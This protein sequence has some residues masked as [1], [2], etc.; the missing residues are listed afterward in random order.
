MVKTVNRERENNLKHFSKELEV[1]LLLCFDSKL[2]DAN[3]DVAT[4]FS[5]LVFVSSI[6]SSGKL[7]QHKSELKRLDFKFPQT[8]SLYQLCRQALPFS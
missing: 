4:L 1:G 5:S 8:L 2:S 3:K 7:M 6:S